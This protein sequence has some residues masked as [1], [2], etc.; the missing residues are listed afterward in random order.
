M[1][2]QT[3]LRTYIHS[4]PR[5]KP[6]SATS[7]PCLHHQGQTRPDFPPFMLPDIDTDSG[8][9]LGQRL[10]LDAA[11]NI[12]PSHAFSIPYQ[13]GGLAKSRKFPSNSLSGWRADCLPPLSPFYLTLLGRGEPKTG[14]ARRSAERRDRATGISHWLR[15]RPSFSRSHSRKSR[16]EA[17]AVLWPPL[18]GPQL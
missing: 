7:H 3:I 1:Y 5:L 17:Q 6:K 15:L 14:Q 13:T 8:R 2:V 12:F 18:S 10:R 4:Y 9:H 11:S 16:Q